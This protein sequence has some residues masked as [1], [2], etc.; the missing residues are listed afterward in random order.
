L[1]SDKDVISKL[2]VAEEKPIDHF[3]ATIKVIWDSS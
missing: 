1:G 3:K 2:F